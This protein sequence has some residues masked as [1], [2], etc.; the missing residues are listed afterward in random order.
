LRSG[1][2]FGFL[3][4]IDVGIPGKMEFG[5][6]MCCLVHSLTCYF[7]FEI[8]KNA[9]LKNEPMKSFSDPRTKGFMDGEFNAPTL[10]AVLSLEDNVEKLDDINSVSAACIV[11]NP[12]FK[13]YFLFIQTA[14]MMTQS[15]NLNHQK[16]YKDKFFSVCLCYG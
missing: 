16:Y 8:L 11:R 6:S 2:V 13:V 12:F 3:N 9:V 15:F 10:E 7:G 1:E 5:N 4:P 14:K